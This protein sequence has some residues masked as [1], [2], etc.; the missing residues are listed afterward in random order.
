MHRNTSSVLAFAGTTT[1]VTLA[2]ALVSCNGIADDPASEV[3]AMASAPALN[4]LLMLADRRGSVTG[5]APDL[6][7]S[8]SGGRAAGG[9]R[10]CPRS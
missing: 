8:W 10:P 3:A 4:A 2:A 6:L 9:P 5:A 1:A 7:H